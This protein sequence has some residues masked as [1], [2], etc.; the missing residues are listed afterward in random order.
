[1]KVLELLQNELNIKYFKDALSR[2]KGA[3]PSVEMIPQTLNCLHKF[4]TKQTAWSERR[5]DGWL[6][7]WDM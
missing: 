1:M 4:L 3:V 6:L 2:F 7:T 5:Q